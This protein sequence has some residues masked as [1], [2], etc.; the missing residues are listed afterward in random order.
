MA[1]RLALLVLVAITGVTLAGCDSAFRRA[2]AAA[3]VG[4]TRIPLGAVEGEVRWLVNNVPD[5][6]RLQQE[7]QLDI[8]TR[9]VVESR[10]RHALIQTA[11]AQEGFAA[12][13]A[14]VELLFQQ[15][16]G[17]E[18]GPSQLG[19]GESRVRQVA[20]DYVLLQALAQRSLDRVSVDYVGTF[21]F[22]EAD[23]ENMA[24]DLGRR[25]AAEP[26]RAREL[27]SSSGTDA[28]D[29]SVTLRELASAQDTA[30]LAASPLVTAD[31][32]TVVVTPSASIMGGSLWLIAL[33]KDR[34]VTD[35]TGGAGGEFVPPQVLTQ[36]GTQQLTPYA[37]DVGVDVNPRFGVWDETSMEVADADGSG[38]SYVLPVGGDVR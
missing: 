24:L 17:T 2:S 26:E 25:V 34:Q 21:I 37:D 28:F 3:T 8:L 20:S 15:V 18:Q 13:P 11:A 35:S 1:R 9:H 38:T 23:A 7:D 29:K 32:G 5:A 4:D 10:V 30:Q 12:D 22:G 14:D 31:A 6:T 16:G 27:L 19:V 36:I 33:I